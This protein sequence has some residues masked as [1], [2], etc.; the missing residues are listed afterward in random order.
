[1]AITAKELKLEQ[2]ITDLFQLLGEALEQ[3]EGLGGSDIQAE[4]STY[5]HILARSNDVAQRY[6]EATQDCEGCKDGGE[7]VCTPLSQCDCK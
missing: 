3:V 5:S 4:D 2:I 7:C 1:M 6:K